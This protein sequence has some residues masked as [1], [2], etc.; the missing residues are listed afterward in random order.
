MAAR[1]AFE[2]TQEHAHTRHG[3]ARGS[4]YG[5]GMAVA[6]EIIRR[7]GGGIAMKSGSARG[8]VRCA[9]LPNQQA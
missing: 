5:L 8:N 4:R 1:P 6:K 3:Q 2:H 9:R 7:H